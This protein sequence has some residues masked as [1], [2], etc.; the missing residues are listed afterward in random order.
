MA[1]V[2]VPKPILRKLFGPSFLGT[3]ETPYEAGQMRGR[4]LQNP[5]VV[6]ELSCI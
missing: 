2:L 1:L 6:E 3:D 4:G 5:V